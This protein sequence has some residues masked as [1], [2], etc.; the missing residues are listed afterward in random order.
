LSVF[1]QSIASKERIMANSP[2][3]GT[4]GIPL[5]GVPRSGKTFVGR[6]IIELFEDSQTGRDADANRQAAIDAN[7]L[8]LSV[9]TGL[10]TDI[11]RAELLQRIAA[12]FPIRAEREI[13]SEDRRRKIA[14][15]RGGT[16]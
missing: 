9:S 8:A 3:A 12:A 2:L 15:D 13:L 7:G 4:A 14:K 5:V 1:K 16:Y 6:I 10:G 11:T